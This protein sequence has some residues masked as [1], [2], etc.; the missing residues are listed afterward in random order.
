MTSTPITLLPVRVSRA[1]RNMSAANGALQTRDR[2]ELRIW[3]GPGSAVHR[4][5]AL[6]AAPRPGHRR[7][8]SGG[9]AS[10][11]QL[12]IEA[13]LVF[14]SHRPRHQHVVVALAPLDQ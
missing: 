2:Y 8:P 3:N 13:A 6:H 14:V 1:Q 10:G 4:S 11:E 7:F 9:S 12:R 5:A